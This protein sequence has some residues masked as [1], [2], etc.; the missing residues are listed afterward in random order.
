MDGAVPSA[1]QLTF[2]EAVIDRSLM[3]AAEERED[4]PFHSEPLGAKARRAWWQKSKSQVVTSLNM[5]VDG[6]MK[7]AKTRKQP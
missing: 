5:P 7:P 3:E 6:P 2:L 1:E 4:P